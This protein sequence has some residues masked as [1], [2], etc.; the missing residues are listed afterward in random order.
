MKVQVEKSHYDFSKYVD[1]HR[2]NSYWNQINEALKVKGNKVLVIGA[3]DGIV[4]DVLRKF[5][6][7]VDTFDFDKALNPD[8]VGSVTEVDEIVKN[9]YDVI[10]CCQVLEHIPFDQ[11]DDTVRRI[12]SVLTDGGKFILSLPNYSLKWKMNVK[13][14]K[15]PELNKRAVSKKPFRKKWDI[16]KDGFGEHYW[17][18]NAKGSEE[19]IVKNILKKYYT[20]E[21]RFLPSDNLYHI[22]YILK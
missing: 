2:W 15:I 17:E 9:K 4:V 1:E 22:F 11:F 18:I 19:K 14:P 16:K 21:K 3:G 8:I 7:S 20:I 6:K 10:L 5:G 12:K 13:L